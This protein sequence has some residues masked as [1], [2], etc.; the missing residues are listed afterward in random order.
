MNHNPETLAKSN[1]TGKPKLDD[2]E[3]ILLMAAANREDGVALP[4]GLRGALFL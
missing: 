1:R 3:T 2:A 4:L